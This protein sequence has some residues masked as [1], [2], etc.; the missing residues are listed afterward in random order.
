MSILH[1]QFK[2]AKKGNAEAAAKVAAAVRFLGVWEGESRADLAVG[3]TAPT[4]DVAE[5]ETLIAQRLAA[6]RARDF[7]EADRI[8]DTLAALGIRLKDSSD[9][10]TWEVAG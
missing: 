8:R 10:T 4:V 6:R 2:S 1:G 7:K 9:G 3:F 5:V